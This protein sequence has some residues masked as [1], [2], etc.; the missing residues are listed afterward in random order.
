MP[1][2]TLAPGKGLNTYDAKS[3]F[4]HIH[5]AISA[6][7]QALNLLLLDNKVEHLYLEYSSA[8]SDD[9][10]EQALYKSNSLK[11]I[12]L[13][14]MNFYPK[15]L[16]YMINMLAARHPNLTELTVRN[17]TSND[18]FP[19]SDG[20]IT[21]ALANRLMNTL[22]DPSTLRS[23]QL[24]HIRIDKE[25]D[26]HFAVFCDA[27]EHT[28]TLTTLRL[29]AVELS[30]ASTQRLKE[31]LLKNQGITTFYVSSLGYESKMEAALKDVVREKPYE[32]LIALPLRLH[33]PAILVPPI[34]PV[35]EN[36]IPAPHVPL[37][38]FPSVAPEKSFFNGINMQI[39]SGFAA[40]LGASAVAISIILLS[41][42]IA[43]GV[44]LV[45]AI[46]LSAGIYGLFSS[47]SNGS[48]CSG[49]TPTP[50]T[51]AGLVF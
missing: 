29:Y 48:D 35:E 20:R 30:E 4:V 13:K 8:Y 28:Q 50:A 3:K 43:A 49:G 51:Q 26:E 25:H 34:A 33:M 40:V 39:L 12:I 5:D 19:N 9:G 42:G 15:S 24:E 36:V 17:Y 45:G 21:D 6:E 23:L 41:G 18:L 31:A 38:P 47:R 46:V 11:S 16:A 32:P 2:V 14:G 27:L 7:W 22:G 1:T 37:V 44:G 10:V